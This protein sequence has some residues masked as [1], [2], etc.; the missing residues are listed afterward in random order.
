MVR[1]RFLIEGATEIIERIPMVG[2]I[3]RVRARRS[4]GWVLLGGAAFQLGY[5]DN[6][7]DRLANYA[8]YVDPCG[9]FLANCQPGDFQVNQADVA[10]YCV[11]PACTIPGQCGQVGPPLGT[12]TDLCP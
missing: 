7:D 10:D 3:Q 9:T 5:I 6:C 11:D 12:I 2:R 1:S 4:A 8:Q